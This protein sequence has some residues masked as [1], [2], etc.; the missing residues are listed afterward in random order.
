MERDFIKFMR[1][2]MENQKSLG[3]LPIHSVHKKRGKAFAFLN[4]KSAEQQQE[5][6]EVYETVEFF[7]QK[8]IALKDSNNPS[9]IDNVQFKVVKDADTMLQQG[10]E[11]KEKIKPTKEEILKELE[12]SIFDKVTPYHHLAYEDHHMNLQK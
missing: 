5:F 9:H 8:K 3:D 11:R 6:K 1:K 4:F 7:K 2:H 12:Q 10:L